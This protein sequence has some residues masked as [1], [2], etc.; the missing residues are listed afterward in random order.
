MR[1]AALYGLVVVCV[2]MLFS[3]SG[4]S[5][6]KVVSGDG[7]GSTAGPVPVSVANFP[8]NQAVFALRPIPITGS[9]SV[10]NFPPVQQVAG[11]VSVGNLPVDAD[12]NLRVSAQTQPNT[13]RWT[14]IA[15][16]VPLI[17]PMGSVT[18][19]P[20]DVAGWK[21]ASVLIRGAQRAVALFGSAEA[22]FGEAPGELIDSTSGS[23]LSTEV[24]G[25]QEEILVISNVETSIDAWIYLSN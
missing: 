12:G 17:P 2:C 6:Q 16:G 10:T 8:A 19:G 5:A 25:P 11:T 23:I 22:F 7:G 18:I 1:K 9:V 13:Y 4:P 15:S 14:Q 20:I 24:H 21:R 3:L